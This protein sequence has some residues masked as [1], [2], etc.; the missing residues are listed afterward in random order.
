MD[1]IAKILYKLRYIFPVT[2]ILDTSTLQHMGTQVP[3]KWVYTKNLIMIQ[4]L[5][6]DEYLEVK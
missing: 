1:F 6:C 5:L 3:S 4:N 2:N